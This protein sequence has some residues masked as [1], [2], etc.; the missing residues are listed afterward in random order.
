ML[1]LNIG[2]NTKKVPL[3]KQAQMSSIEDVILDSIDQKSVLIFVG[4]YLDYTTELGESNGNSGGALSFSG[5]FDSYRSLPLPRNLNARRIIRL[6]N[7]EFIV[8][9]NDDKTYI[10]TITNN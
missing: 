6:N 8:V 9:A 3:P 7:N 10:F 2:D 4:N 1:F 5:T